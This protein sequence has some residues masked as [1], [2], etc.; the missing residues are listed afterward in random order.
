[1]HIDHVEHYPSFV[2]TNRLHSHE[3]VYEVKPVFASQPP[4]PFT[5]SSRFVMLWP[6]IFRQSSYQTQLR[7]MQTH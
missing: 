5:M 2:K 7:T 1:M 4:T 6:T 3:N